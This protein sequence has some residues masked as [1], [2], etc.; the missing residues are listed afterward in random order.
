MVGLHRGEMKLSCVGA[1]KLAIGVIVLV[2]G[3]ALAQQYPVKPVRLFTSDVG[4]GSDL[5]A[6]IIAQGISA[7]LGQQVVV[8]NRAG[9]IAIETVSKASADGH[10]LLLNGSIIWIEPLLR[11][12][13]PWDSIKA[14]A[15]IT[16][17]AISPNV[18]VVHPSL[19]ANSVKDLIALARSR[20]GA[21]NY[22]SGAAGTSSHTSGELFKVMAGVDI[23]RVAYKGTG[24]AMPD[25]L[26][27]QVQLMFITA[28]GAAPHVKSGRLRALAVT[29]L[30]K[31]ALAPNL[32]TVAESGLPGYQVTTQ[33]A[34]L[35]PAGTPPAIVNRVN[36]EV[37]RFVVRPDIKEKFFNAGLEV[38]GDSPEQL[39]ATVRTEINVLGKLIKSAGIRA[40]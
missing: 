21:L 34:I 28:P 10:T 5:A 22:A 32:S 23:V 26:A 4:G 12:N 7:P 11:D 29:S 2:A 33:F 13:V 1:G 38:V 24:P 16:M 37:V 8:E 3:S 18:L 19:P 25:L 15:P 30:Q 9:I 39:A 27:G 31:S 35:A 40:D 17:A 14:F 6:R 36:Q 20:P